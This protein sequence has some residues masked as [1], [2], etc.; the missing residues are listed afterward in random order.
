MMRHR[1]YDNNDKSS[2]YF[3]E[4]YNVTVLTFNRNEGSSKY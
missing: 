4:T 1:H 3:N 2:D